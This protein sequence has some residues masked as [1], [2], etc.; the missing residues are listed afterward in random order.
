MVLMGCRI[1]CVSC[2]DVLRQT[3][4]S[5]RCRCIASQRGPPPHTH[6]HTHTHTPWL[7]ISLGSTHY[8]RIDV[9]AHPKNRNMTYSSERK[10]RITL[11]HPQK[12]KEKFLN[13][14]TRANVNEAK[15]SASM[16]HVVLRASNYGCYYYCCHVWM[17]I[18]FSRGRLVTPEPD[19]NWPHLYSLKLLFS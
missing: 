4:P 19:G 5:L 9:V 15:S 14:E 6:T 16:T 12:M 3:F 13:W 10:R 7:I 11:F 1:I 18:L 8:L 2:S 17:W